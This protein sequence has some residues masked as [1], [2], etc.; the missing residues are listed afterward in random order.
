MI[1]IIYVGTDTCSPTSKDRRREV[2]NW[3]GRLGDL[4]AHQQTFEY[5]FSEDTKHNVLIHNLIMRDSID[6]G[7]VLDLGWRYVGQVFYY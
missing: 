7:N 6:A 1:L 5:K 3:K 2:A 4:V